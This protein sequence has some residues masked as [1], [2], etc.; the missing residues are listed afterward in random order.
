MLRARHSSN[1]TYADLLVL[2]KSRGFAARLSTTLFI[3][4]FFIATE[5]DKGQTAMI[6]SAIKMRRTAVSFIAMAALAMLVSLASAAVAEDTYSLRLSEK[7]GQ[8]AHTGDAMWMKWLMWDVGFQRMVARNSPYLELTNE[9]TS[10]KNITEFHITIGD[11]RFNFAD[12]GGSLA[13]LGSTTPGFTLSSS[14]LNG[15]GDE[16]IVNV[17]NGGLKPGESVRFKVKL[18]IDASFAAQYAAS[19]GQSLPDYRT[20]FFD[21]NGV[22]VYD[23]TT[24]SSAADNSKAYVVFDPNFK[25][26]TSTF[27]DEAVAVSQFFNSNLRAYTELDPVNLFQLDGTPIPEPTSVGLMMLGL[28][29]FFLRSRSRGR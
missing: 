27:P 29:G 2:F 3:K 19:F 25:S 15:A 12:A 1:V 13:M 9:S 21:M 16:L 22:N 23:G 20:V 28:A 8:L 10:T 4:S 17:G 26:G 11:N 14:T 7:E 5:L 6:R 24:K 18:G